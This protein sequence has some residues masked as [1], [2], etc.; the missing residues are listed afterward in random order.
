[1]TLEPS[2]DALILG[3]EARFYQVGMQVCEGHEWR[4][5]VCTRFG[6]NPLP[7]LYSDLARL[8]AGPR[9]RL[10]GVPLSGPPICGA[11]PVERVFVAPAG[12]D[13]AGCAEVL[14]AALETSAAEIRR[15]PACRHFAREVATGAEALLARCCEAAAVREAW[16]APPP[17]GLSGR[18]S[19]WKAPLCGPGTCPVSRV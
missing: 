14:R 13:A 3:I 15:A 1:M 4:A 2:D 8:L 6:R 9:A 19:G 11:G 12:L 7:Q 5:T 16:P 18:F 10:A 17:C